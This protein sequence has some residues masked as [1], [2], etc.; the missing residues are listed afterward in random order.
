MARI[1]QPISYRKRIL[2]STVGVLLLVGLYFVLSMKQHIKNHQ[3]TTLPNAYQLWDGF[4]QIVSPHKKLFSETE[5][6]LWDNIKSAWLA[7]DV[8]A[9][10]GR[11]FKGLIWGCLLSV[12]IGILAGCYETFAAFII[13]VTSV[14]AKAPGTAMLAV[15]FVIVGTGEPMYVAMIGFGVMPTLIQ[16]VYLSARDDLHEEEIDKAYTLGASSFEVIWN[17]VLR[18]VLPKLIDSIR[19]QI[20]PAMVCLIA[21]EMLIGEVGFGY[22][23]RMQQRL[24][25]M[26][27]VYLYI[28]FLAFSGLLL[29]KG[30]ISLRRYACPWYRRGKS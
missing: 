4:T 18:Q 30:L 8:L 15:F 6:T 27:V 19:L 24:L 21:A 1:K 2:L 3:D 9:T 22:R 29:D 5:P 13:P 7:Q 16:A 25:H 23:I 20:G 10:Y 17:I 12:I 28:T 11:L 14:L 26:N